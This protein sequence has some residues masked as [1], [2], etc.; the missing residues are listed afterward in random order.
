VRGVAEGSEGRG[1]ERR[2]GGLI[3]QRPRGDGGGT[4]GRVFTER[5]VLLRGPVC[6]ACPV[7]METR[8]PARPLTSRRLSRGLENR[9]SPI[10]SAPYPSSPANH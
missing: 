9:C 10:S 2:R 1:P 8:E 6:T 7:A 5:C 4:V 3:G